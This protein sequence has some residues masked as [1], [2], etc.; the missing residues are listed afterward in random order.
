MAV[1]AA[2]DDILGASH[3]LWSSLLP[4]SIPTRSGSI[5]DQEW[6]HNLRKLGID[7]EI[8]EAT[9]LL[10][11]LDTDQ[12]GSVSA[13]SEGPSLRSSWSSNTAWFLAAPLDMCLWCCPCN[14]G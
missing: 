4:S 14:E 7:V 10:M 1:R 8:S 11:K 12:S 9:A 6:Y 5:D 13:P 2:S 3:A